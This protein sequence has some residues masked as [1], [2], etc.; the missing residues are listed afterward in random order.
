MTVYA[1]G[2]GTLFFIL[3][4][5]SVKLPRCG[6]WMEVV[7]SLFG[8]A[9]VTLALLYLKDAYPW[10]RG[11]ADPPGPAVQPLTPVAAA[12]R[13]SACCWGRCTARSTTAAWIEGTQGGRARLRR[14]RHLPAPG[15]ELPSALADGPHPGPTAGSTGGAAVATAFHRPGARRGSSGRPA[16]HRPLF[17]DFGAE[18]CAACKELEKVTYPAT[19][20]KAEL[21]R[22]VTVKVDGTNDDDATEALYRKYGVSGLPTVVFFDSAGKAVNEAKLTGFEEPAKF[23]SRLKKV[24]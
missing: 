23:L 10:A 13:P 19:E 8:I 2:I 6:A 11:G 17:I 9:L 21:Q 1:T 12:W 5:F 14:A 18:W 4:A 7:K 22:F 16:D 15:R 3:A 24:Q 20:V